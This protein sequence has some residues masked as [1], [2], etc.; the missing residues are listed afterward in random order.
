MTN[1]KKAREIRNGY[2]S[3]EHQ[4]TS[5]NVEKQFGL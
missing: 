5:V 4:R 3:S 2:A 1:E